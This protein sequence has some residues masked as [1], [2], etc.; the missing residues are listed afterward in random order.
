MCFLWG[1][2]KPTDLISAY[3]QAYTN[4]DCCRCFSLVAR[5]CFSGDNDVNI[6]PPGHFFRSHVT[7]TN[8]NLKMFQVQSLKIPVYG[9]T[10][11]CSDPFGRRH[12]IKIKEKR[13]EVV[14]GCSPNKEREK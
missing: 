2:G 3:A 11:S 1:T 5:R 6:I 7:N 9:M 12:R 4:N 14:K 8:Q 13:S 10:A